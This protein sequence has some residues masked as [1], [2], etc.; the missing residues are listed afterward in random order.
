MLGNG[1][2][3]NVLGDECFS[4]CI[5][6]MLLVVVLQE[7]FQTPFSDND[8]KKK[9][10]SAGGTPETHALRKQVVLVLSSRIFKHMVLVDYSYQ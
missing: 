6:P 4:Q 7:I 2:R 9:K 5:D 8:N 1:L 10:L 3:R